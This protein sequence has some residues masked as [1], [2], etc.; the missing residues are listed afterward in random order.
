MIVDDS[1]AQRERLRS[2]VKHV[3]GEVTVAALSCREA[4]DFYPIFMTEWTICCLGGHLKV[5]VALRNI[6]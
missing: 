3:G 2:L 4:L 5:A 6:L 1:E